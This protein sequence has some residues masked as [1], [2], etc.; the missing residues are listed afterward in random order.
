ML[1]LFLLLAV[2]TDVVVV[3]LP[4]RG[5]AEVALVPSGRAR[6]QREGTLTTVRIELQRMPPVAAQAPS[7]NTYVAWSVSPEGFFENMGELDER[8]RIEAT[9]RFDQLG[10]IITAEPHYLVDRPSSNVV[11]RSGNPEQARIRRIT[12]PVEVGTFD[13]SAVQF[14]PREALPNIIAQSRFALQIAR[15]VEADR[16][17]EAEFRQAQI[18]FDT[19][20]EMLRR[21]TPIEIL[22]PAAHE[23][24]RKSQRA[25]EAA[26]ERTAVADL[27]NSRAEAAVLRENNQQLEARVQQLTEQVNTA[28]ERMNAATEQIRKLDADLAAAFQAGQRDG[29][30]RDR[31]A[32]RQREL[33]AQVAELQQKMNSVQQDLTVRLRDEF[34][35]T[36]GM[37]LTDAGREA[38][39]RM[40]NLATILDGPIRIEG[41]ASDAL[42]DAARRF[43]LDG[44]V[45]QE[46]IVI[47]R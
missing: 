24:I 22:W 41:P 34:M 45:P 3:S 30:E 39:T 17:A 20:E 19:Q 32:A 1:A 27:E 28:T 44:G 42:F 4:M 15:T 6:L 35:A 46:R 7:A 16:L 2:T 43:F 25:V 11:Y 9:T 26:R 33:E 14:P 12:V 10:I 8:G 37:Q 38:L 21:Q 31:L 47:A 5:D 40:L 23:A 18:A 36:D 13:Y 29:Q